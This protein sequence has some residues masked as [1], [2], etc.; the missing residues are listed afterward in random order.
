MDINADGNADI[1]SEDQMNTWYTVLERVLAISNDHPWPTNKAYAPEPL[2]ANIQ[3]CVDRRFLVA[4]RM[5]GNRS[6]DRFLLTV[7]PKGQVVF[8]MLH[9][10]LVA[11]GQAAPR[12]AEVSTATRV[13]PF[14]GMD[15]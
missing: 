1:P 10:Q 14:D 3:D 7:T 12:D 8:D 2:P 11:T 6:A 9:A 15:D 4:T 5:D 13:N